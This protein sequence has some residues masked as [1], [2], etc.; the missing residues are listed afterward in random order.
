MLRRIRGRRRRGRQKMRCLDGITDSMDMSLSELR[1]LVMIREAW[2]AAIQRHRNTTQAESPSTHAARIEP[3]HAWTAGA[4][5][6]PCRPA[7]A[8]LGFQL[9]LRVSSCG[10]RSLLQCPWRLPAALGPFPGPSELIH[11]SRGHSRPGEEKSL[12]VNIPVPRASED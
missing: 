6:V 12:R 10:Q 7:Q 2:L 5:F 4:S 9:Q 3:K 11:G 8:S 1:E